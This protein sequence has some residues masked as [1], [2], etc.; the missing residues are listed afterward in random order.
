MKKIHRKKAI[1]LICKKILLSLTKEMRENHILNYWS[2]DNNDVEFLKLSNNLQNDILNNDYPNQNILNPIY[3]QLIMLSLNYSFKGVTNL[4]LKKK[5]F[6]EKLGSYDIY[7]SIEILKICP[8][9]EYFT[10]EIRG[11]S[12]ICPLCYWEDD[13]LYNY[14]DQSSFSGCNHI[15]LYTAKKN[16]NIKNNLLKIKYNKLLTPP[17]I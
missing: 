16:F 2:I 17:L 13:I 6:L 14:K 7:G 4:F 9:C 15:S 10:L 1:K 5:L 12:D 3:N 11:E 8:C